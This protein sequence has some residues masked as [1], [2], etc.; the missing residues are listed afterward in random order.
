MYKLNKK[1]LFILIFCLQISISCNTQKTFSGTE[2][3]DCPSYEP[4]IKA[5]EN[6]KSKWRLVL[7][8][9]G[10]TVLG[11]KKRGKSRLFRKK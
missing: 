8:K 4:S 5:S 1:H 2:Q 9:D 10:E 7:Y 3:L 11:K 6:K